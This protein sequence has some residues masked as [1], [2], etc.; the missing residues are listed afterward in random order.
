MRPVAGHDDERW[1]RELCDLA[2]QWVEANAD[3]KLNPPT[4]AYVDLI[5]AFGL[6]RLGAEPSCREWLLRAQARLVATADEAHRFLLEAYRYRIARALEGQ[7]HAG[8]LPSRLIEMRQ[9]MDN[10]PSYAVDRLRRQSRIL[11]P[12]QR[13]DPYRT[14]RER[15][16]EVERQAADLPD[17]TDPEQIVSRVRRLLAVDASYR[18]G[19]LPDVL[20]AVQRVHP[21]FARE[22]LDRVLADFDAIPP[23]CHAGV[24]W[25]RVPTLER[26]LSLAA[27]FGLQE[28]GREVLARLWPLLDSQE[29]PYLL[30]ALMSVASRLDDALRRL[31]LR[32]ERKEL[33]DRLL[34]CAHS[35][36]QGEPDRLQALLYVAGEWYADGRDGEAVLDRA[37]SVL[38]EGQI[39]GKEQ[40]VLACAYATAATRAPV[41]AAR[42]RLE[43]FFRRVRGVHDTFSTATHF[44]ISQLDVIEA[45]VLGVTAD[46]RG[47][48]R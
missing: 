8:P 12:D 31:G 1:L 17:L 29:H 32:E 37:R 19:L 6:A 44:S 5:F 34:A 27:N 28:E 22:V 48:G 40:A 14:V 25:W 15:I 47:G 43:E 11:E 2:Q 24:L 36:G 26:A 33:L 21:A 39:S 30:K 13:I 35:E 42:P 3:K 38:F 16:S 9:Q 46:R 45:V 4:G 10:L 23:T 7:A 18:E 41:E 20:E